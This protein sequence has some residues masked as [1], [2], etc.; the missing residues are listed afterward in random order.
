[1][2]Y[3]RSLLYLGRRSI[4]RPDVSGKKYSSEVIVIDDESDCSSDV[5]DVTDIWRAMQDEERR[6]MRVAA[7]EITHDVV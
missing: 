1:M 3:V 4:F 5:K 6:K 2:I 7:E